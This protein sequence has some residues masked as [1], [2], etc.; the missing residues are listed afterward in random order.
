MKK[1]I[2]ILVAGA[3]V[4]VPFAITI[5]VVVQVGTALDGMV[6][7]PLRQWS[8]PVFPGVGAVV[9]V[10]ALYLVGLLTRFWVFRVLLA[11][12]ERFVSRLPGAK[13]VYESVRDLL[14]LFG[15]NA[16][17]MGRV[18]LYTAPGT[19]MAILA[20]LTNE[21]PPGLGEA[22]QGRVAIYVPYSYMFG[23]ITVFVPKTCLHEI[24]L[25]V[26]QAL[27]LSATAQVGAEAPE[28]VAPSVPPV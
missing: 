25:S 17:R 18:V 13:T 24:D 7:G 1:H 10:I 9:V 23:G 14:K 22:G 28:P 19:Q 5:W 27:K 6:G 11:L 2:G 16:S 12:L 21:R 8:F 4:V 26:E 15:G 3:L 20:I